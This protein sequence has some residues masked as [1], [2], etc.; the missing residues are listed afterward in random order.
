MRRRLLIC[1]LVLPVLGAGVGCTNSGRPKGT[2]PTKTNGVIRGLLSAYGAETGGRL[3]PLA[4]TVTVVGGGVHLVVTVAKDGK[5]AVD[6]PPG[7]YTLTGSS[8]QYNHGAAGACHATGS[9]PVIA[10]QEIVAG[11]LCI[12]T[13]AQH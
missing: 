2:S 12:A 3:V 1:L 8:P 10:G 9:V 11:V 6:L 7:T 13:T 4:G 5:F